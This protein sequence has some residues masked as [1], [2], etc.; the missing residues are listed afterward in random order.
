MTSASTVVILSRVPTCL[1]SFSADAEFLTIART[2]LFWR[3]EAITTDTPMLP[4]A[5]TTR[6]VSC[7]G[8]CMLGI[9]GGDDLGTE[10]R[11]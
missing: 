11:V 3:R 6:T 10:R 7:G 1:K 9:V 8:S 5:P 2:F 4:V